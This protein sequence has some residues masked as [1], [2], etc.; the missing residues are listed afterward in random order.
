MP[1]PFQQLKRTLLLLSLSFLCFSVAIAQ[2]YPVQ[3]TLA[4]NSPYPANLSDYA[5]PNI[6]KLVLNLT[7]TDLNLSNKR[8]RL[9][10]FIQKQNSLIAQ[11]VNMVAGESN[12][13]LDGGVPQR[14]TSIDLTRYFKAENLQGISADAYS[15]SLPE[16]VYTIGFEVYDFFTGNKLSGRIS[17]LFWLML[18]DPPLLNMPRNRQNIIDAN[19]NNII[20]FTF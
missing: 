20:F 7:L 12:I 17:Q 15:Q 3:G 1:N 2:Q 18:S 11:S 6:E 16:G 13:V 8:V 5:N 10:I 19:P 14:F 9:K 4:I